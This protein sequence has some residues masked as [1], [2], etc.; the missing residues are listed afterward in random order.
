MLN[1]AP[2]ALSPGFDPFSIVVV[3]FR[4]EGGLELR[5]PPIEE[6]R[7]ETDEVYC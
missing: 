1:K 6:L 3:G 4:A 7:E 5:L 2:L